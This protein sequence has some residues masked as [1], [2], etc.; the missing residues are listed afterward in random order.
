MT[1]ENLVSGEIVKPSR[2]K[3]LA[4]SHVVAVAIAVLLF[5]SLD[6]VFSVLCIPLSYAAAVSFRTSDLFHLLADRLTIFTAVSYL[7]NS[8][9]Y[10]AAASLLSH[11]VFGV[12]PVKTLSTYRRRFSRGSYV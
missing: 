4:D 7:F 5:W 6:S 11:L 9:V 1:C 12:G 10:L 2:R 8:F 3:V